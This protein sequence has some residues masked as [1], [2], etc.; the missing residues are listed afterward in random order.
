MQKSIKFIHTHVILFNTFIVSKF[1]LKC[2]L[3][4]W[5][6]FAEWQCAS[7]L[8]DKGGEGER[9]CNHAVDHGHNA[10]PRTYLNI[11]WDLIN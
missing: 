7:V 11:I 2:N 6:W 8:G 10:N 3:P 9:D 1:N 5:V 4:V